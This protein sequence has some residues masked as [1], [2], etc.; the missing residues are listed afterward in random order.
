[1][2]SV[3]GN[4]KIDRRSVLRLGAVAGAGAVAVAVNSVGTRAVASAAPNQSP[5]PFTGLTSG[6]VVTDLEVVTVTDTSVT[7]SWA[8]YA[9]PHPAWGK[10]A[11]LAPADTEVALVPVDADEGGE[12]PVVHKDEAQVGYHFVT[13]DKLR[14]GTTYRFECRSN[15]L[16][17]EPGLITRNLPNTPEQTGQFTTLVAPEGEYLTTIAILNDAHIGENGHGIITGDFP[18]P[19]F[20]EPGATPYSEVMLTAALAE[21]RGMVLKRFSSTVMPRRKHVR[22]RCVDLP[23]L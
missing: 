9:G 19:I 21:L 7:F 18:A 8:T 2:N 6:L 23:R 17:A 16:V 13:V 22:R 4:K 20:S 10:L 12:L 11:P 5:F 15:G 3:N 14:P 1:M